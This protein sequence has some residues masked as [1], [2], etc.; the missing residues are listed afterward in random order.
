MPIYEYRCGKCG[1]EFETLVKSS[2]E[3]APCPNCGSAK[4]EKKLSVFAASV[5]SPAS[6]CAKS[7]F[8]PSKHSCPSSCCGHHHG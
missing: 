5:A 6:S 1:G 2:S 4:T 3:K 8:C 7:D